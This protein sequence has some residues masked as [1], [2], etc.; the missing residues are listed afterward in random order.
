ESGEIA[1]GVG[2]ML[3]AQGRD[4]EAIAHLR[5]AAEKSDDP[6]RAGRELAEALS[7]S[8]DSEQAVTA[9]KETIKRQ[10]EELQK[11]AGQG[12]PTSFTEER[13]NYTKMDMIRELMSI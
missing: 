11:R 3:V 7:R 6:I 10:E 12:M 13:I 8:G 1:Y 4:Q 9:Y 5:K 2:Q